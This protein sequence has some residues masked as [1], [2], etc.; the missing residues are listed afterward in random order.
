MA[1]ANINLTSSLLDMCLLFFHVTLMNCCPKSYKIMKLKSTSN[2]I[3]YQRKHTSTMHI[4]SRY[5]EYYSKILLNIVNQELASKESENFSNY[6]P[7]VR[8]IALFQV[9]WNFG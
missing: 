1:S 4:Y 6:L 9:K 8:I 5:V 3:F 2:Q 7:F